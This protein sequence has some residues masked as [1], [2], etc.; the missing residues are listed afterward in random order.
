MGELLQTV[1]LE[2]AVTQVQSIAMRRHA[3]VN[4]NRS[5]LHYGYST[6][7]HG[8][9]VCKTDV[10]AH[11]VGMMGWQ[12]GWLAGWQAGWPGCE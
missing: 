6:W 7:R 8:S 1:E 4:G 5:K 11:H 2:F 12:V 9:V 10:R 3:V